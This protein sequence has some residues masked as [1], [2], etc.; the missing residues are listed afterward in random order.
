VLAIAKYLMACVGVV[1]VLYALA[2]F[3]LTGLAA[4]T[5]RWTRD[6]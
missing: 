4:V 2:L 3:A 1:F 5:R 6:Q